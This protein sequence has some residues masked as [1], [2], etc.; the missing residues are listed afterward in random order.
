[1][2]IDFGW[3]R[4]MPT[5]VRFGS[6]VAFTLAVSWLLSSV[7]TRDASFSINADTEVLTIEPDC[8]Q[9]IVWDLPPGRIGIVPLGD[10]KAS[11]TD[12]GR[13]SVAFR[14]GARAQVRVARDG[15]WLIDLGRGNS[16]G[17]ATTAE[18]LIRFDADGRATTAGAQDVFYSSAEPQ[19]P[20]AGP[21]LLLKGRI[22]LGQEI[23]YGGGSAAGL[24]SP[25]LDRARIEVRTPDA[26]TRQRRLI[27]EEA[28]D[29]G[30][31]LDTHGCLDEPI[32]A[33]AA[34]FPCVRH[35]RTAAEGFLRAVKRDERLLLETQL[36]VNGRHIGVR[37]QGGSERRVLITV[38]SRLV[39]SSWLQLFAAGLI[40]VST[41]VGLWGG[42]VREDRDTH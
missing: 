23:T 10:E 3:P 9:Q 27:H 31:M 11:P 20:G 36:S 26:Q 30:G 12:A 35:A 33:Q 17:C 7:V 15:R 34:E 13:I 42:L 40:L 8:Q 4:R 38:W 6:V 28:L 18:D 39:S 22:V 21:V 24:G 16:F 2:K 29:P 37:Q 14:G 41:L 25:L 5:W 32:D 19:T 1:M